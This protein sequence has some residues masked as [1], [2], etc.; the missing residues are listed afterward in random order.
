MTQPRLKTFVDPSHVT[1]ETLFNSW[2]EEFDAGKLH[3]IKTN[4]VYSSALQK[5]VLSV[6]Y[7]VED[8][9]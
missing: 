4:L 9:E 3:V 6:I 2:T 8:E 7:K 5:F 1:L